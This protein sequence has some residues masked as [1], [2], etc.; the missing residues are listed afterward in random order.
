VEIDLDEAKDIFATN[1][2][3]VMDIN[4]T[5]LR[6]L[7]LAKG[8]TV[9][10]GSVAGHLPLPFNSVYCA[11]KAALY[12]YCECLRVEL[13]PLGVKVTY[14]QTGNIKTNIFRGRTRLREDSIFSPINEDFEERQEYAATTGMDPTEFAKLLAQRILRGHSDI[15]W[16]GE[17]AFT[18]RMLSVLEHYLPFRILPFI[19]SRLYGLEKLKVE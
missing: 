11:S 18:I 13:A 14:V 5:F 12:A 10:I 2:F 8:T 6:Q 17:S 16:V 7:L 4:Q 1:V 9:N 19:F 15:L 3:G